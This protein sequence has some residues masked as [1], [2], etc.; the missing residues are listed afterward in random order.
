MGC[1]DVN[2]G[3]REGKKPMETFKPKVRLEPFA[4]S[5]YIYFEGGA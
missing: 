1:T 3:D 4:T 5:T 2:L